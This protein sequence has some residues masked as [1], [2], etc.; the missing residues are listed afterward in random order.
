MWE[1]A[2]RYIEG[3]DIDKQTYI[4]EMCRLNHLEDGNIHSGDYL[5]VAYY[6]YDVQ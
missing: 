4:D 6:S 5:V 1:L 3:Y 2:D